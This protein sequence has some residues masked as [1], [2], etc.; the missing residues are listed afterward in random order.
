MDITVKE[1]QELPANTFISVRY[2]D[3]RKQAPFKA[4]EAFSFPS[5]ASKGSDVPKAFT[6]DVF[7]KVG[8]KQVSLAGI[9]AMGGSICHEDL[10]IPSLDI[11]GTP[12]KASIKASLRTKP[13]EARADK[14]TAPSR[15]QEAAEKARQYIAKQGVQPVLQEMFAQLLEHRPPDPLEFL[16]NFIERKRDDAEAAQGLDDLPNF[17]EEPGLGQDALPGF[18]PEQELPDLFKHNSVAAKVLHGGTAELRARLAQPC[19]SLGISLANCVKAGIDCLG[20]PS[21]TLGGAYAGDAESYDLFQ[22]VFDPIITALHPGWSPETFGEHFPHPI[23]GNPAKVTNAA[24][25]G[26]GNYVTF[27]T[28]EARRNLAGLR[29]PNCCSKEERRKVEK[30]LTSAEG[31]KGAYLPLRGSGSHGPKPE[32]M[33]GHQEERLKQIGVL[34]SD[35]DSQVKLAAGFGRHWPDARGVLVGDASGMFVWCNEEDHLR[36]IAR[37]QGGTMKTLFVRLMK[38][39][40]AVG[41]AASSAGHAYAVSKRHGYITTCPSRL[42]CALRITASLKLPRLAGAFDLTSLCKVMELHCDSSS[43]A[44]TGLCHVSSGDGLSMSEVD[45]VNITVQG[46]KRLVDLEKRLE[47]GESIFD[48]V[49][50]LGLEALPGII[51]ASGRCP[52]KLP[53]NGLPEALAA[54]CLRDNLDMYASLRSLETSGGVRLGHCIRSAFGHVG[55][56]AL[57]TGLVAGDAECL[58]TFSN[59]FNA[60]VRKL[61]RASPSTVAAKS[62]ALKPNDPHCAWVRVELRRN[63]SGTKFAPCCTKDDRRKVESLLVSAMLGLAKGGSYVPLA[64]SQSFPD[65]PGGVSMEEQKQLCQEGKLF[66]EPR[67]AA[68]LEAG[69]GRDWPDARGAFLVPASTSHRLDQ[70]V[71]WINEEDHLRLRC[72]LAGSDLKAAFAQAK[73]MVDGIEAALQLGF[74]KHDS[75]GFITVDALHLGPAAQLTSALSLPLLSARPDFAQLCARLGL[76]PTWSNRFCLLSSYPAAE[77][78]SEELLEQSLRSFGALVQLEAM[79]EKGGA[80]DGALAEL[81][82]K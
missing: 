27:V 74:A 34:F 17:S 53:L 43:S 10:E 29:L 75:F 5:R 26:S 54:E 14:G 37:Q 1:V 40:L 63:L 70:S 56:D 68:P 22:E 16:A 6:V 36:F 71:A 7:R 19:T 11:E 42:G 30:I 62:A 9:S 48:A 55:G 13:E 39:I 41:D 49:P 8:S 46:C 47:K 73:G 67:T 45:M 51:S 66:L 18:G 12:L 50:G 58:D 32:G 61:P 35:P 31:L 3:A 78:S 24:A 57:C 81:G 59:L 2:G 15:K 52:K 20:H 28:M 80:L 25:D 60:V 64:Y 77:L 38:A 4:G 23:D 82:L 33:A 72:S 79:L 44:S 21:L 65:P 76:I 69:I